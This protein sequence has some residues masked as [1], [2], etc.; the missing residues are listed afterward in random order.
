MHLKTIGNLLIVLTLAFVA[1]GCATAHLAQGPD[2]QS[3]ALRD[4]APQVAVAMVKDARTS[5]HAGSVGAASVTVPVTIK[6]QVNNY[7]VNNLYD[8]FEVNIKQVGEVTDEAGATTASLY[9]ANKLVVSQISSLKMS[10]FDAIMQPVHT[11]IQLDLSVYDQTGQSIH[12]SSYFGTYDERIGL[13][14]SDSKTGQLVEAS[15]QD[16][17]RQ[18]SGDE[19]LKKVL[20]R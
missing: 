15:V 10:S 12:E 20:E 11:E 2:I 14:F 7:L 1:S 16:L 8:H 9:G 13:S 19:D 18:V 6:N 5:T 4:G 17:M 3:L